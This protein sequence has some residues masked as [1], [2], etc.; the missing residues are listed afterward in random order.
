MK[1]EQHMSTVRGTIETIDPNAHRLTV[2]G[3]VLNKTFQAADDV[4]IGTSSK[5]KAGWSDLHVGDK[6]EVSYEEQGGTSFAHRIADRGP[7]TQAR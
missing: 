7:A 2:H 5:P 4:V 1:P 3:L 6:V